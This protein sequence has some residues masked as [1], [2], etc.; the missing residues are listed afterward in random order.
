[1][2]SLV[3]CSFALLA[4]PAF[5]QSK[6]LPRPPAFTKLVG[7]R[8]VADPAQR[9]A[10]YDKEVAAVDSA[11]ARQELVIVDQAQVRK[12][13]R[14]LF[15]LTLPD[16]P[17]LGE[18][19]D[20]AQQLI[21]SAIKRT[22]QTADGKWGFELEDGARWVQ[23]DSRNLARDPRAGQ[24]IRIRRAALGSYLANVNKQVGI[25]VRRVS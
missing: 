6:D 7:C 23:T 14:S 19:A 10:C 25:R 13:R 17:I 24:P 11:A 20:E 8:T 15:G 21:E 3:A 22:W 9:L 18:R 4:A 2:R 12:A 5:A 16:I 1:M